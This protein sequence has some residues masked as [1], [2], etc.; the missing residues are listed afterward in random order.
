MKSHIIAIITLCC[1]F[2]FI[3]IFI[4]T[5]GPQFLEGDF[6]AYSTLSGYFLQLLQCSFCYVTYSLNIINIRKIK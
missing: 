5:V 4:I 1:Y 6:T 3:Y 2:N